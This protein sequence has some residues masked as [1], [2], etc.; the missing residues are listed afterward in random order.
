MKKYFFWFDDH[1]GE[2]SP[3]S[4]VLR[5][6]LT[7]GI[8]TDNEQKYGEAKYEVDFRSKTAR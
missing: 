2:D 3:D 8:I 4:I 7:E 6:T 1:A 5:V